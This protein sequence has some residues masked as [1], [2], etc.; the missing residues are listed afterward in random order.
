[1]GKVGREGAIGGSPCLRLLILGGS[2]LMH[3]LFA[4][5]EG[6]GRGLV[7]HGQIIRLCV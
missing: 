5:E 2:L 7:S 6:G 3:V 1:M 4:D